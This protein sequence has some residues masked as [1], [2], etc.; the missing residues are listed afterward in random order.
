MP[1]SASSR[2][3]RTEKLDSP[4]SQTAVETFTFEV[5]AGKKLA[6][7]RAVASSGS[8]AVSLRA[9]VASAAHKG[10]AP[11]VA[12]SLRRS[13]SKL[14]QFVAKFRP[15]LGSLFVNVGLLAGMSL[16]SIAGLP[17]S[18]DFSLSFDAE[19]A[20]A[21]EM[22]FDEIA[23][24]PLENLDNV[25]NQLTSE[26]M[27]TSAMMESEL[28]S[29]TVLSELS[30]DTL[31]SD[32]SGDVSNLL[33]SGSGMTDVLPTAEQLTASF[34]GT[35]VDGER[36]MYVLDNSGGMQGGELELLIDELL[37]SVE[38][39]DPKQK[40]Y[41]IF[42]S[43]MLY[44]L[45]YPHPAKD[46]VPATDRSK[47]RL[48]R[49]LDT[50]EFC[51]GNTVDQAIQAADQ[52]RP[53]VVYLLT[54]GQLDQTRDQ[55]RLAALLD[56]RG[57]D[58]PIHTFGFLAGGWGSKKAEEQLRQ[59]A[60][61]NEGT[62]RMIKLTDEAVVRSKEKNRPYHDKEPGREWGLSVGRSWGRK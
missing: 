36:I 55:R 9:H 16:I 25:E 46:F 29:E 18:F 57:R 21:D 3:H 15:I 59:V 49:W 52:A 17:Q 19:P 48:R 1:T 30:S 12:A 43:D 60:E 61:G 40:F 42:Y 20:A 27:Q 37:A 38:S 26:I 8:V 56:R 41:V 44:P 6:A 7:D 5:T 50:V 10:A 51:M 11:L 34:F 47:L 45:Y 33:A 22:V 4:D 53:D 13:P 62:F 39:L 28:S 31:S 58:Y 54:D 14:L 32:I 35:K 24:E 23:V 2:L